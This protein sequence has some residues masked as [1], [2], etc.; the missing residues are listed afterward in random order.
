MTRV[1]KEN[2]SLVELLVDPKDMDLKKFHSGLTI[3]HVRTSVPIQNVNILMVAQMDS[4]LCHQSSPSPDSSKASNWIL[5][6]AV[7][8][9]VEL[10]VHM[11]HVWTFI[12]PKAM[13]AMSGY[14]L[15][16]GSN[17]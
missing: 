5:S 17:I 10:R 15:G 9:N 1:L 4:K 12:V 6:P 2:K 3:I 7:L 16:A 11:F 8:L 13:P 14:G